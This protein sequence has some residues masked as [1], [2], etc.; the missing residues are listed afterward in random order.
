MLEMERLWTG[1][2]GSPRYQ[3]GILDFPARS[4]I[5]GPEKVRILMKVGENTTGN[6]IFRA[7][8]LLVRDAKSYRLESNRPT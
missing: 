3:N 1:Q 8:C 4:P 5:N 7:E 6:E 2:R